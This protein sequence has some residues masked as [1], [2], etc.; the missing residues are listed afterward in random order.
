[1]ETLQEIFK[2]IIHLDAEGLVSYAC[3]TGIAYVLFTIIVFSETGLLVGFFLPGDSLLVT[4]GIFASPARGELNILL[5]LV[6]L[7]P[8]AIL[9]NSTGY[10]IGRK[11]G[12]M[13]F[14]KEKSFFF[15]K[16]YLIKTHEFYERHG[17]VTIIIAQFIPII[18]TFAPTVAG[19]A[20]MKY[21]DFIKY[22]VIGAVLWISSMTLLGFL[23]GQIFPQVVKKIEYIILVVV[24]LSILP[25]IIKFISH[26]IK[27][28]KKSI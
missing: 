21:F 12:P 1:M 9:G 6:L 25:G 17:G 26:K 18:R 11:A 7:I 16:D 22:N 15:R 24:F 19:I 23:L 27:E 14:K 10:L 13:L 5:L 20:Q 2:F 28:R 4:A 8:A 3:K